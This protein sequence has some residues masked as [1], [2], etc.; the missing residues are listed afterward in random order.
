MCVSCTWR[1][2]S[3]AARMTAASTAFA[4]WRTL[5]AHSADS[6]ARRAFGDSST[7]PR[8]RELGDLVEE[9]GPM[10]G[11]GELTF[12]PARRRRVGAGKRTEELTFDEG[13]RQ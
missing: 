10:F 7:R 1:S 2:P 13:L 3:P 11:G 4:S 9:E 6:V 8:R 5:P 12:D